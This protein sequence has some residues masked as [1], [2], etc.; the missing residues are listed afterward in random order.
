M[1]VAVADTLAKTVASTVVVVESWTV[2]LKLV[3][4]AKRTVAVAVTDTLAKMVV[5]TVV[6]VESW[7]VTLELVVTAKR[8]VAVA[9]A[10]TLAKVVASTVVVVERR[11][12]AVSVK[13]EG[14][15][16][17]LLAGIPQRWTRAGVIRTWPTRVVGMRVDICWLPTTSVLRFVAAEI[18]DGPRHA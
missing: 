5:S 11:A 1:F 8:T 6:V 18:G 14:S 17:M 3:V 10:D 4:T 9:V 2:T 7:T 16:A 13:R 12:V 15:V